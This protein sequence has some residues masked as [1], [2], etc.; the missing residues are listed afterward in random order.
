MYFNLDNHQQLGIYHQSVPM[1]QLLH[2]QPIRALIMSNH[3]VE[4][5]PPARL[6]RVFPRRISFSRFLTYLLFTCPKYSRMLHLSHKTFSLTSSC[7]SLT[8]EMLFIALSRISSTSLTRPTSKVSI[9]LL[10]SAFNV[11]VSGAYRETEKTS[12]CINLSIVFL[13]ILL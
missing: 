2:T 4:D 9:L 3:L 13:E 10:S 7:I 1:K 8:I 11:H 6:S 5:L 12:S